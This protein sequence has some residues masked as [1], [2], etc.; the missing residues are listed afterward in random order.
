MLIF[1]VLRTLLQSTENKGGCEGVFC[2]ICDACSETAERANCGS[3]KAGK[4][5]RR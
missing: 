1:S 2:T 5:V 3:E 4:T